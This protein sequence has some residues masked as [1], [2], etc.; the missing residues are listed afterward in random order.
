MSIS[1]RRRQFLHTVNSDIDG[2]LSSAFGD[3]LLPQHSAQCVKANFS[4]NPLSVN[5]TPEL[6]PLGVQPAKATA[7]A[8]KFNQS[9][10]LLTA[11]WSNLPAPPF[12]PSRAEELLASYSSTVQRLYESEAHELVRCFIAQVEAQLRERGSDKVHSTSDSDDDDDVGLNSALRRIST[13]P[14]SDEDEESLLDECSESG[15]SVSELEVS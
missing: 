13:S 7:L 3:V 9:L 4:L 1:E 14:V 15:D 6:E 10:S 2:L 12:E 8:D 11:H 5:I